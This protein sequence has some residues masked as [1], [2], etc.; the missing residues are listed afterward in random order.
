MVA[1][2]RGIAEAP[3]WA[4]AEYAAIV[5]GGDGAL[6]RCLLVAEGEGRLLGFA[7]GKVIG[8]GAD[9]GGGVGK[10]CGGWGCAADGCGQGFV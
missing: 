7:V 6:R 1:L 2:E 5:D 3:H 4:E 9:R 10:R 8:S